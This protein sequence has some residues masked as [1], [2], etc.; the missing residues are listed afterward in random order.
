MQ[1]DRYWSAPGFRRAA[2]LAASVATLA[3]M[4]V[5]AS[6]SSSSAYTLNGCKWPSTI[7]D[8]DYRRT[9]GNYRTAIGQAIVNYNNA[10]PVHLNGV[11]STGASMSSDVANY[12]AT[13]WEAF[14]DSTCIG[15]TTFSST[16]KINTYYLPS[17]TPVARLKVVWLHELGHSLGLGHASAIN[18]V[19]Y[20]SASTAYTSGGVRGLTTDEIAGID[21]LY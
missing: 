14:N 3:T 8:L 1:R 20:T 2:A 10:T 4:M 6:A 18:R 19:M 17:S 12:G 9:S 7:M 16:S 11:E 15:G 5:V 13:G 21:Y